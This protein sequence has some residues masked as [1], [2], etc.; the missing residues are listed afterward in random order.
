LFYGTL[1][2]LDRAL[3]LNEALALLPLVAHVRSVEVWRLSGPADSWQCQGS[4]ELPP[5]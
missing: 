5:R 3:A 1:G 4:V 2:E